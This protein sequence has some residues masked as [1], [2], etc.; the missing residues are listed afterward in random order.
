MR[1]YTQGALFL[2]LI[3]PVS[4]RPGLAQTLGQERETE[5]RLSANGVD[6]VLR[7]APDLQQSSIVHRLLTPNEGLA[8]LSAALDSRHHHHAEFSSDC[9][10]FVHGLY[11]SAGFPYQYASSSDLFK[12]TNEFRRVASPQPGDLAVWRGHAGIVVDPERHSFFSVLHS[13]P[14]IESYDSPYWKQRGKLR[15]FRYLK[16]SSDGILK[17]SIRTASWT[18]APSNTYPYTPAA[19]GNIPE[20]S[21]PPNSKTFRITISNSG[22]PKSDQVSAAFLRAVADSEEALGEHGLGSG[23][24]LVVFDHFEVKKVY[25]TGSQ[26]WIDIQIDELVCR[27]GDKIEGSKQPERQR[28]VLRRV[29]NKSWE[30]IPSRNAIY[31]PRRTAE[32]IFARELAQL[33]EDTTDDTRGTQEKADLAR[34]LDVLFGK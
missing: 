11:A 15:F 5:K 24:S 16:P 32:R 22:R 17:S 10:H 27:A 4:V 20:T 2:T 18:K 25:A 7:E 31:L 8:I 33:T 28:W 19:E 21:E 26:G 30:I 1:F 14:G 3:F 34:L 29:D 12:G 6:R 9:S 13:G 23:E